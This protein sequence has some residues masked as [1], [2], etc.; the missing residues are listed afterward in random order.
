[1]KSS[2]LIL[3]FLLFAVP[4]VAQNTFEKAIDTLLASYASCIKET[5][6]GGYIVCG[7]SLL[8]GNDAIAIKLDSTGFIEWAKTY[9]GPSIEGATSIE[10]LPDSGYI[11]DGIYDSG[12]PNAR[13]WLLRLDVNG[14]TLWTKNYSL[15]S[16]KTVAA[17]L[18]SSDFSFGLTGY[19]ASSQPLLPV[20]AYF[21]AIDILGN[22]FVSKVYSTSIQS[23]AY[24]ISESVN[25]GFIITGYKAYTANTTDL[26]LI[27]INLFGDTIWTRTYDY[28]D[29]DVGREVKQTTDSGYIVTG[30]V[31]NSAFQYN[32]FLLKTNAIG[33]TMWS[34]MI[35]SAQESGG[36][37]V[38]QTT[39]GGYICSGRIVD[40]IPLNGNLYL[41]RTDSNGD[42]LWTRQFGGT[43]PDQ[44]N[45][46]RQTKD[47]GFIVTGSTS[48]G[49]GGIYVIKLDSTGNVITSAGSAEV[50]N[51]FSFTVY[52]NPS[53]GEFT[54][55]I[56]GLNQPAQLAI[57]NVNGDD[58]YSKQIV[59]K[60]KIQLQVPVLPQGL[61][62]ISLQ[63]RDA[64]YSRKILIQQ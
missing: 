21:I 28:S 62:L 30:Y 33:D 32:L 56:T 29:L 51:P 14:D 9:S 3:S 6:D 46:V 4:L 48:F 52:P 60:N 55:G 61:Y 54:I 22:Q 58:V 10:Q 24:S 1:M 64:A 38:D 18:A 12:V 47:G 45:F 19:Y 43:G 42:T 39:D 35:F 2:I 34:R 37:S 49:T 11:M 44:G 15:G 20:D 50:N 17:N 13:H 25:N 63:T 8:N 27:K 5:Y 31:R 59:L 23:V 40:G 7:G 36:F 57:Y 26:Y 41:I 53:Q 16:G